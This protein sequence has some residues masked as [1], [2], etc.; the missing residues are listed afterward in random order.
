LNTQ[1][2]ILVT[3]GGGFLGGAIVRRLLDKD[4]LVRSF[5]RGRYPELDKLGVEQCQGDLADARAVTHACEGIEAVFHV[6]AKAGVWGCFDDYYQANVKGTQNII[7]AC[8][9][10]KVQRLVYT[11]SPSV[12][13][14]GRDVQGADES[15]P[16]PKQFH[17]PYP[18]TKALAEQAVIQAAGNGLPAVVLRPHLIWGPGDNH[19][20]PRILSRAGRLRQVGDGT[21]K[22]DTI[23]I[24]NAAH[25]HVLAETKLKANL[26]LSGRCYFISQDAPMALWQMVNHILAAGG[27]PPLTKSISP[28]L[29]KLAGALCEGIYRL[30]PIK[31]EPPMTRFVAQELATSHW[32]NI[33]AAKNDLG[34]KPL[35]STEE[36]LRRLAEWIGNGDLNKPKVQNPNV[37]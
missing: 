34:Y 5:S 9:A 3:G 22:V 10:C 13:F 2:K 30:L 32:F 4:E 36:G 6:A 35:V 28:F 26:E 23:Y 7:A 16:Y 20:V 17:A 21:N 1:R 14:D 33:Q 19:L 8:N 12:V 25:A 29:A 37:K 11:S 31:G 18:Q 15:L 24:D 27:K